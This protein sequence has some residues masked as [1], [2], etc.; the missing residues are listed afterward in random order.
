MAEKEPEVRAE[1]RALQA[2]YALT[3]W[4][5]DVLDYYW[6]RQ[7]RRWR[8]ALLGDLQGKVLELG[9]GTGRN[10]AHYPRGV[11]VLGVDLSERMLGAARRRAQ[12]AVCQVRL[13]VDDAAVL[14]TVEDGSMDWVISTFMCCVMPDSLQPHAVRQLARALRPGGRFRLL[15]MVYSESPEL[16]RRQERFAPFVERVYGARFD[17]QT[18]TH[19]DENP[20][21]ELTGVRFLK[22]DTYLLLEGERTHNRSVSHASGAK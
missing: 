2:K 13:S 20:D 14:S 11:D 22:D 8:P 5:Y 17:R 21:L 9:V 12:A 7:Y 6:E 15:E 4:V 10:L 16:R 3:G 18:R 19:I 1:N